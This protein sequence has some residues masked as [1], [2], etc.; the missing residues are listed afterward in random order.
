MNTNLERVAAKAQKE[1][2]LKF[3]LHNISNSSNCRGNTIS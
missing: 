1:T 2:K 3:T